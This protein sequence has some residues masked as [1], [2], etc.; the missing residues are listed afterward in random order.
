[1]PRIP[2]VRVEDMTAEQKTQY[3]R[4]PSNLT[5][6]LL[7]V[8]RRLA[9]APPELANAL[10]AA[11]LEPR[12]REAVIL[13]VAA[14]Q[15]SAYERMQHL[16]PGPQT[17]GPDDDLPGTDAG[18]PPPELAAVMGFVDECVAT[19]DVSEA[20]F[21]AVLPELGAPGVATLLLLIGHYMMIARFTH[22]LRVELDEQPDR[23]THDH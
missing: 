10:R 20:S 3:D 6:A 17:G 15:G 18:T 12:L 13:R 4:F 21:N 7:L 14:L 22:V 16:D 2:L 23:W 5:R 8:D 11:S 9:Q 1:M 19:G